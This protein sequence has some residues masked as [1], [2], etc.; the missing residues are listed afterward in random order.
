MVALVHHHF[1]GPH[2]DYV[3]VALAAFLSWFGISGPGEAALIAAGIEAA[4]GKVDLEG[5]IAVAW[6]GATVGGTVGWLLGLKGGRAVLTA[7]GPLRRTRRRMLRS[8]D[9]FYAKYGA[10]AVYFAP[11]WMA[12]INGMRASRFIPINAVACA[13]W[14]LLVGLGA[15]FAGPSITDVLGDLGVY[16]LIALGVLALALALASWLR[17]RRRPAAS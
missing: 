6:A 10:L 4:R 7:G 2:L 16:G 11:S 5:M 17:R 15:Y 8:G 3:G 13:I 9:R 14:A 12:G 1:H